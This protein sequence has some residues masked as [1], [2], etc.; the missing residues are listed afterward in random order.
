MNATFTVDP[1]TGCGLYEIAPQ[2]YPT[3]PTVH[4]PIT[5]QPLPAPTAPQGKAVRLTFGEFDKA[6]PTLDH[7]RSIT[8]HLHLHGTP[9]P[10]SPSI[11][12]T[13]PE[14]ALGSFNNSGGAWTPQL[15]PHDEAALAPV[16]QAI[17]AHWRSVPNLAELRIAAYRHHAAERWNHKQDNATAYARHAVALHQYSNEWVRLAAL[18]LEHTGL[19]PQQQHHTQNQEDL[20]AAAHLHQLWHT[21][22]LFI[23][24]V[25]N[26]SDSARAEFTEH[27]TTSYA[28]EV[29]Q[30]QLP[31]AQEKVEQLA[32]RHLPPQ[33]VTMLRC[34]PGGQ[35][36]LAFL[37]QDYLAGELRHI[38]LRPW[39]R[40][41]GPG[42]LPPHPAAASRP[43]P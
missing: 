41:F 40:M 10:G 24:V 34:S 15:P 33:L 1:A 26:L 7:H 8:R 9:L 3:K 42:Q 22:S 21:A 17:M 19:T 20:G 4:G 28:T 5:V 25:R 2:S 27:L 37:L 23:Q 31:L 29:D 16:L 30:R 11:V 18:D 6:L 32:P 36:A 12:I 38:L 43:G 35:F 39:L 14:Q 13:N